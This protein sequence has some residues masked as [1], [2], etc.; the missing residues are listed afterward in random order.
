VSTLICTHDLPVWQPNGSTLVLENRINDRQGLGRHLDVVPAPPRPSK[1][2]KT[3]AST[4]LKHNTL[5]NTASL[6]DSWRG[7][8]CLMA[9]YKKQGN[10]LWLVDNSWRRKFGL[11]VWC[12]NKFGH[13]HILHGCKCTRLHKPCATTNQCIWDMHSPSGAVGHNGHNNI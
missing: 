12:C 11:L 9:H 10:A 2:Q 6:I 1:R 13:C 8:A 7:P 4:T 5:P 3:T